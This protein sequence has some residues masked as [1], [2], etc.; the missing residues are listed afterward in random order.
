MADKEPTLN[1][2]ATKKMN[3]YRVTFGNDN[4]EYKKN[5]I[6]CRKSWPVIKLILNAAKKNGIEYIWFFFEPCVEITWIQNDSSNFLFVVK[7][8]LSYNNIDKYKVYTPE[9]GNFADW[10]G[11]TP[12]ELEF[13]YKRYS[14]ASEL[15]ALM[16]ENEDIINKG[17]GLSDH[18]TRCTHALANPLGLDYLKEG[19][20]LFKRSILCLLYWHF[21]SDAAIKIHEELF[22]KFK[23]G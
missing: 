21:P 20:A 9:D 19:T 18:F 7:D 11:S 8:L 23:G 5:F 2:V 13:G 3:N 6:D 1:P 16:Y 17:M 4:V 14:K 10:F 22:G 12:E 15:V